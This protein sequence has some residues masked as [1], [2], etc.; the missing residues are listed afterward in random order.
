MLVAADVGGTKTNLGIYELSGDIH[1]PVAKA[2]LASAEYD[3]MIS[4]VSE[5]LKDTGLNPEYAV[6]GVAGPVMESRSTITNLRWIIEENVL[7]KEL[8]MKS[9]RLLNDLQAIAYG[10]ADLEREDLFTLNQGRKTPHG[11][12]AVIAP[13][14]GLGE[15]YITQDESSRYAAHSSEGGH[16]DFGPTDALET[17]LLSHMFGQYEHVSYERVCSGIGIPNIYSF[18][19]DKEGYEEPAWLFSRLSQSD[20]KTKTILT[21]AV[22]TSAPCELCS[23]TLEVFLSI[24]GAE[25]GNL[26]LKV[27]ATGGV[28]LAGGIAPKI[29]SAFP[30]SP[31]MKAFIGKGRLSHVLEHIPVNIILNPEIALMG[32]ARF[33]LEHLCSSA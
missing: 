11:A 8:G 30:E 31:F 4:L 10:I 27:M 12:M 3:S 26:A 21:E 14:T 24:L 28:Y 9:V 23:R 22:N 20:D 7:K 17:R 15:A 1:S 16:T 32:A 19:R 29:V 25:A 13:G 5:F 33:G 6:F 2:T 18:L